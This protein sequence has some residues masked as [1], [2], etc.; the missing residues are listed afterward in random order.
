MTDGMPT[1]K[2][3]GINGFIFT[4]QVGGEPIAPTRAQMG[5]LGANQ[6]HFFMAAEEIELRFKP[7]R[8]GHIVSVHPSDEFGFAHGD[9]AIQS[10]SQT[11][12]GLV[13]D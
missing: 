7:P 11:S 3:S 8:K 10:R 9:T 13:Y 5:V 12:V 1:T 2:K 4:R 6:A